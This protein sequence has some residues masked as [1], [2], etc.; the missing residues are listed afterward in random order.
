MLYAYPTYEVPFFL[1]RYPRSDH[2]ARKN[3]TLIHTQMGNKRTA[4]SSIHMFVFNSI[5]ILC[6]PFSSFFV[7]LGVIR[8]SQILASH[9]NS[10]FEGKITSRP[11]RISRRSYACFTKGSNK[12]VNNWSSRISSAGVIY[13]RFLTSSIVFGS[14]T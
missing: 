9:Y 10:F 6:F 7:A 14:K 5:R 11:N 8:D 13:N 4:L 1:L 12:R 2:L 3:P